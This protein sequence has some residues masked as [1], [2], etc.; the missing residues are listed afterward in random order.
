MS[1]WSRVPTLLKSAYNAVDDLVKDTPILQVKSAIDN[2]GRLISWAV[3]F[4]LERAVHTGALSCDCRWMSFAEP[5]G[6]YLEL[7]YP[8]SKVS[9]SQVPS[10]RRQPRN[11]VFRENARLNNGQGSLE[12]DDTVIED[13]EPVSGLPHILLLHGYQDLNF[14][15]WAVPSATSRS[16]FAWKSQNLMNMA[17]LVPNEVPPT[18]NTDYDLNEINL[19]KERLEKWRRDNENE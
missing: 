6:R 16:A 3:D 7:V 8:H 13:E 10:A 9:I 2:K 4:A 1:E 15:H 19:L 5:T 18:E 17:H 14:A 12:L 11:V